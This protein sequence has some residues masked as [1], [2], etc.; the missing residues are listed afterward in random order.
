MS[1]F[2]WFE[3]TVLRD[4][5]LMLGGL[6]GSILIG[7]IVLSLT[8]SYYEEEA[9]KRFKAEA[10]EHAEAIERRVE[11]YENA[12]RSGVAFFQGSQKISREE[13][14]RFIRTLQPD[15]YYPGVQG[16]G[17]SVMLKPEELETI[18]SQMQMQGDNDFNVTPAG[19]REEYSTVLYL[20]PMDKRN[21]RAIGYDMYSEP[22][23][24]RAMQHSRDTASPVITGK[25]TLVQE[26]DSDVQAGFLMY[27]PL[28]KI[29][30]KT[31]TLQERRNALIGF[32]YSPFRMKELVKALNVHDALL[33]YAIYDGDQSPQNLL[34]RSAEPAVISGSHY[35]AI[36][37][38][39]I[40]GRIWRVYYSSTPAFE[41]TNANGQHLFVSLAIFSV[42]VFLMSIIFV[43]S[44]N[45][46]ILHRQRDELRQEKETAQNYLDIVDVIILVCDIRLNVRLINRYGCE[47]IGYPAD[48]VIGKNWIEAFLPAS[49]RGEANA[50]AQQL[51]SSGADLIF[52]ETTIVTKNRDERLIAWRIRLL[53]DK[54]DRGVGF[55]CSGEDVTQMRKAQQ[56]L[57]ESEEFYRTIFSSVSE[58]ILILH[59]NRVVDCNDLALAYFAMTKEAIVGHRVGDLAQSIEC[60]N[61]SFEE[62]LHAAYQGVDSTFECSWTLVTKEPQTKILELTLSGLGARGENKTI[63]IIRDIGKRVEEERVLKMHTRQAQMGEMIAVIAHQWRQPLAIINAITAQMRLKLMMG[64]END[65]MMGEKLITIEEQSAHLSQT[66]SEYRDF[67]HPNKPREF[68]WLSTVLDHAIKLIDYA[69]KNHSIALEIA[70]HKDAKLFS[71]RNEVLQVL[72]A[73]LKNALDAFECSVVQ[74]KRIV[75]RID[76]DEEYGTIAI[77]DNAAEVP[78]EILEKIFF[79]Y[80]TTKDQESGTGLGLYMSKLII[81]DHCHGSIAAGNEDGYAV[82]TIKLPL[83]D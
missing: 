79:P 65:P 47:V 18:M 75:I 11:K 35:H 72:I 2:N 51:Q 3:K 17:Y 21:I 43:L 14:H 22:V 68:F 69:L 82:F 15:K 5:I 23:R 74:H 16:I 1:F 76:K 8:G 49:N 45:R 36:E 40:G 24:R 58:A 73:L 29:G 70:V 71:Y 55:L 26:I 67:F 46:T 56:K 52:Y 61:G 38:I 30:E 39:Q 9:H 81:E 4:K 60:R 19:K 54:D 83:E 12:L 64:G 27:L 66:I 34:Y 42:Y 77:L 78:V 37:S 33:D 20:E 59:N 32:V 7:V 25:V 6:I 13:W 63:M 44:Y 10:R 62:Y 57:N 53:R 31:A 80:F 41:E 28:Y 50:I 48:E